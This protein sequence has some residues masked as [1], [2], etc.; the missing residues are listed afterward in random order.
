[1]TALRRIA[2]LAS[3]W[4][5]ASATAQA[6]A[7]AV[8]VAEVGRETITPT[9]PIAGTV[10]SRND[11]QITIGV[12]GQ[13]TTVLEP[14]T[15]VAAGDVIA[16]IDTEPLTLQRA[17]QVAQAERAGSLLKYLDAQVKR[18]SNL[19]SVSDTQ[20]DQTVSDRDVAAS[21]LRIARLRIRQIDEQLERATVRAPFDGVI[22]AR[23]RREGEDVSRG[24]VLARLVDVQNLEVRVQVP[25][26]YNG[27]V[28]I[29]DRLTVFGFESE[30][31]GQV[32]AIVPAI[33]PRA[34]T[35]E[36][37]VDLVDDGGRPWTL[38]ELVSVAVPM[39]AASESLV[40]PRDALILR[41][42]GAFVFR[43]TEEATA[44]RVAVTPG[45][46]RGEVVA[47][48]GALAEGERV[49]VRGAESLRDGSPVAVRDNGGAGDAASQLAN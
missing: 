40:V 34:Q 21:D 42:E 25:L 11:L 16:A 4:L 31:A 15:V 43:I 9:V 14:G 1:M 19:S 32:R 44:E 48:V 38:G 23:L 49:V 37:R 29:G 5:A 10:F 8:I 33:D 30:R 13:L 41:R 26:R 22:A 20:R 28:S 27:R 35:F 47:V 3:L 2:T 7:S 46:S 17:E 39:R 45:D 12:D 6:P 18:Q 36:L 24:T